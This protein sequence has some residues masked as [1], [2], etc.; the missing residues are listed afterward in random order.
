[1]PTTPPLL[2]SQALLNKDTQQL[3][4][5]MRPLTDYRMNFVNGH[6]PVLSM[7]YAI[8]AGGENTFYCDYSG[9]F[10]KAYLITPVVELAREKANV[11]FEAALAGGASYQTAKAARDAAVA[12]AEKGARETSDALGK[13]FKDLIKTR[14]AQM[15]K[16]AA[17]QDLVQPVAADFDFVLAL[18]KKELTQ[19]EPAPT[20]ANPNPR[21]D[22]LPPIPMW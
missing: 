13:Q 19:R 21:P 17:E 20:H 7:I 2:D 10:V 18:I 8:Y 6:Y 9:A 4:A 15:E 14:A 22:P 16:P 3:L 5:R 11:A 1:M 12:A